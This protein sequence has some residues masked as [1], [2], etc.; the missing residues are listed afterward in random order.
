MAVE[1]IKNIIDVIKDEKEIKFVEKNVPV[2]PKSLY[3]NTGMFNLYAICFDYKDAKK[4]INKNKNRIKLLGFYDNRKEYIAK[5]DPCLSG[6]YN[7]QKK[8][9]DE[10]VLPLIKSTDILCDVGCASGEFT[11][12]FAPKCKHIDGIE[13]FQKYVDVGNKYAQE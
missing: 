5:N 11:Y 2:I 3:K 6:V 8:F 10:H 9:L 4:I 13:Y 7:G 12:M 1:F